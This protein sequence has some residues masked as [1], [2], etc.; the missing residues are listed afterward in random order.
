MSEMEKLA[1]RVDRVVKYFDKI[2]HRD[3]TQLR[4]QPGHL[5]YDDL[6]LIPDSL[7]QHATALE[8]GRGIG[9]EEAA[10]VCESLTEEAA[11]ASGYMN[12]YLA[13]MIRLLDDPALD[14]EAWAETLAQTIDATLH[15]SAAPARTAIIRRAVLASLIG[16][17]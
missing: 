2:A 14:V 16:T 11:K 15:D 3:S 9:R 13:T 4:F 1:D 8:I 17:K 12:G 5:V 7:R 6:A 10:K